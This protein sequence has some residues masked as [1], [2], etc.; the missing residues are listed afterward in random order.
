MRS[1][2]AG[3][4]VLGDLCHEVGIEGGAGVGCVGGD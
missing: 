1:L 4:Y 3:K 2:E